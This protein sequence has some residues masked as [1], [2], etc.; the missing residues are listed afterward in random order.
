MQTKTSYSTFCLRL[1]PPFHIMIHDQINPPNQNCKPSLKVVLKIGPG[2]A[3]GGAQ[4]PGRPKLRFGIRRDLKMESSSQ[5]KTKVQKTR[6]HYRYETSE[7]SSKPLHVLIYYYLSSLY[8][9][10]VHVK[11]GSQD[12][13][14]HKGLL[15]QQSK[16]FKAALNGSSTEAM[17]GTIKLLDIHENVFEIIYTWLYTTK[18]TKEI[19]GKDVE[20]SLGRTV[21]LFL[22]G[23]KFDMP[24]LCN[25][26]IDLVIRHYEKENLMVASIRRM[27]KETAPGSPLR[28]VVVATYVHYFPGESLAAYLDKYATVLLNCPEFL[29]DLT[30]AFSVDQGMAK[31]TPLATI[32]CEFHQHAEGEEKCS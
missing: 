30:K 9:E 21:S 7:V 1:S 20:C 12:F 14:I 10:I 23:Q 19:D 5:S 28:R 27:Y 6:S 26:S 8:S 17:D 29:L 16:H 31:S 15:C 11:V 32:R 25:D 18:L 4:P 2:T 3:S 13:G 24:A 22:F